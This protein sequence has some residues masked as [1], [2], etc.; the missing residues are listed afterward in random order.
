MASGTN[1]GGNRTGG[2]VKPSREPKGSTLIDQIKQGRPI[3]GNNT[4]LN[5]NK[6]RFGV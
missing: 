4:K 1:D 5:K 3:G 6:N 2:G